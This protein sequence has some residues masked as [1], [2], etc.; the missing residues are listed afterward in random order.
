MPK[1]VERPLALTLL[2]LLGGAAQAQDAAQT[3]ASSR[4]QAQLGTTL[5]I[6][7]QIGR[8][9][10]SFDGGALLTVSP[11]VSWRSQAG[12]VTGSLDYSLN[13]QEAW[14]TE[15]PLHH[16]QNALRAALRT[17]PWPGTFSIDAQSQIGQQTLS[18]F[19]A[20][21]TS[22]TRIGRETANY[23][24]VGSLSV[25]PRLNF[26]LGTLAD[27]GLRHTRQ[28]QR[29]RGSQQGDMGGHTTLVD[30]NGAKSSLLQWTAQ[31]SHQVTE[32]TLSR[33]TTSDLAR[34][35][36]IWQ[37]DVDWRFGVH[38]GRE[39]N[40]LQAADFRAG[41]YYGGELQW[42]PSPRTQLDLSAD[43]RL[44]AT[45]FNV[46]LRQRFKRSMLSASYSRSINLPGTV[47]QV[48]TQTYF[49][50][51]YA[52]LSAIT[53]LAEREAAALRELQAQGHTRDEVVAGG[54]VSSGLSLLKRAQVSGAY[55]LQR[56]MLGF[57]VSDTR[58]IGIGAQVA[59]EDLALSSYVRQLSVSL[60]AS[61]EL[62]PLT[63]MTLTGSRSRNTG[64]RS[65]LN[66][67]SG[68]LDL[69]WAM[70][71]GPKQ[72]LGLTLRHVEF[73]SSRTPYVENAFQ[74]SLTQ[75]F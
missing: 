36:L 43:H 44:L 10:R 19:G 1:R 75:L 18:A 27:G 9:I 46:S 2:A 73:R 16:L 34:V 39:R 54:F 63:H 5:L 69:N 59:G 52:N 56:G 42:S 40:N 32:P 38:G 20:Q 57:T 60:S 51:I 31:G 24:E 72:H 21:S 55:S 11:G 61:Y 45:L 37:P 65:E 67:S 47:A 50:Q 74:A 17:E 29:T 53:D 7:D 48:G 4:L 62:T 28:V 22:L 6:S 23:R 15:Q 8:S 3:P 66:N 30:L 13:M 68:G 41:K 26:R 35:G 33:P 12:L 71:L 58:T 70:R 25:T 64:N 49:D 14:R